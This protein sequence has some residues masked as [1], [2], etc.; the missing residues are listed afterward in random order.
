MII[1]NLDKVFE[2]ARKRLN[3]QIDARA[4]GE[5]PKKSEPA[6]SLRCRRCRRPLSAPRS[7]ANGMG[8]TCGARAEYERARAEFIEKQQNLEVA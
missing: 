6:F 7:V 8:H 4:R 1:E 2:A 5:R 3:R